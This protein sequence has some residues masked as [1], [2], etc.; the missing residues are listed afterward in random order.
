MAAITKVRGDL[1]FNEDAEYILISAHAAMSWH[2]LH[3]C[4]N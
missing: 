4:S 2:M 3:T 1:K